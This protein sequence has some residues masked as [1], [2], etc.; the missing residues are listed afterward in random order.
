MHKLLLK[1]TSRSVTSFRLFSTIIH[2]KNEFTLSHVDKSQ[3]QD[4]IDL[5]AFSFARKNALYD[6]VSLEIDMQPYVQAVV[7]QSLPE[8][9]CYAITDNHNSRVVHA[10][11]SHDMCTKVDT[12]QM[13]FTPYRRK[14][15][16]SLPIIRDKFNKEFDKVVP[17]Q[18]LYMDLGA[19]TEEYIGKGLQPWSIDTTL[20]M[21]KER[22]YEIACMTTTNPINR[23]TGLKMGFTL[24]DEMDISKYD[25][26][27]FGFL[28]SYM[29]SFMYIRL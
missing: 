28:G 18:V 9:F 20:K 7:H 6:K 2:T 13:N 12:S 16:A 29:V 3:V 17:G 27:T 10:M 4:V 15:M 24:S 5:I 25:P 1:E 11:I 26:E 21:A 22:G 19:T 23:R 8:K 14:I